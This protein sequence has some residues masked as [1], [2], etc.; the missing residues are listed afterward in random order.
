MNHSK[1]ILRLCPVCGVEKPLTDFL[2][3]AVGKPRRLACK[4]CPS[5]EN[6]VKS[7]APRVSFYVS[8]IRVGQLRPGGDPRDDKAIR[9]SKEMRV[10]P[11]YKSEFNNM[12]APRTPVGEH[13][14][15]RN[16]GTDF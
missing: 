5:P 15:K 10:M 13:G 7:V 8:L 6:F 11:M 12:I 9:W 2:P 14:V 16:D 4:T 3:R 1:N